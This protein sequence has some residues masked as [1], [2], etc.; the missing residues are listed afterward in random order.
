MTQI[1]VTGANGQVGQELKNLADQYPDFR[2]RFIDI[3]DLD[4]CKT[5]EVRD[6]FEQQT[7]DLVANCCDSEAR[8]VRQV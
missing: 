4:I 5:D 7:F 1:L 8:K 3:E 2:F 6:F